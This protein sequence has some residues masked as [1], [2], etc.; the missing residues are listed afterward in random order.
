DRDFGNHE[1]KLA[2]F[3]PCNRGHI[4]DVE[5]ETISQL[6]SNGRRKALM[7]KVTVGGP[8]DYAERGHARNGLKDLSLFDFVEGFEN[9]AQSP[10]LRAI[11]EHN[12]ILIAAVDFL[13]GAGEPATRATVAPVV[14]QAGVAGVVTNKWKR[15]IVITGADNF[16]LVGIG[17]F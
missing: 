7:G 4:L 15:E 2:A 1:P 5:T 13:H 14:Q 9:R 16:P 6:V 11:V 17:H 12:V 8:L 3:G 10:Q